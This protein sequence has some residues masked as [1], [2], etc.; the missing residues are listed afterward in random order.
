MKKLLVVLCLVVIAAWCQAAEYEIVDLG[1]L[2]GNNSHAYD[3]NDAGHIVGYAG[4][5]VAR[6]A[7]LWT[8]EEGMVDL[9]SLGGDWSVAIAINNAGQVVGES[10]TAGGYYH[11]F[12]WTPAEGMID[13]GT[14]G[15]HASG[16]EDIND[17]GKVVGRAWTGAAWH[18]FLWTPEAGMVDL[19]TLGG[20]YTYAHAI[21]DGGQVM[22][23][24]RT[25][26]GAWHAFVWTPAAG[27]VDIGTLG[28]NWTYDYDINSAGQV[29]GWS[30]TVAGEEHAFLWTPGEGM[31]DLGTLGGIHSHALAVNDI[32]HI[33][34][35]APKATATTHAFIWTLE[36]GMVDLG[37]LFGS[38][39]SNAYDIN[40]AGQVVG[41]S[42]GRGFLWTPAEGMVDL[43]TLG[44][45][46]S[47]AIAINDAGQVMGQSYVPSG[48][49]HAVLWQLA[50]LPPV[51][52]ALANGQESVI[53]DEASWTGTTVLL[54]GS[55]SSDPD[56]D[57]LTYE[58]DFTSDGSV[59]STDAVCLATYTLGGPYT[60]TLTV[61][62]PHGET[63][64]DT[65][66]VT[67]VPGAP[68]N[69]LAVLRQLISDSVAAGLIEPEIEQA[70]L[71]K[72]DAAIAALDR[73]DPPGARVAM[74]DLKALINQVEAQADNKIDP[75]VA[76][77]I[78]ERANL[79]IADLG[80]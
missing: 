78:I 3:M 44:G 10:R 19:G 60:A 64:S 55:G 22:G 66:T 47:A 33:V 37:T 23:R 80:G 62:D 54:D 6:H 43:G 75:A 68:G 25:A 35:W 5:G 18:A 36:E 48:E 46:S 4:T 38:D 29:V 49:N 70:L 2:G 20:T 50:N 77:E 9:G 41:A 31:I 26:S 57:E 32:G 12:L 73:G 40:N 15:G 58:W 71:A 34:G 7:F 63:D 13:L 27:M 65:V 39:H 11:A 53:V 59:D 30:N 17:A 52:V 16:A 42:G 79:I 67:V 21:N 76:A 56:G 61:T 1:T 51:A 24:A 45:V 28:G 14:L 8:P 74:N 72:V 69:Q